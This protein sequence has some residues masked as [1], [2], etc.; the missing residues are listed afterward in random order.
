MTDEQ[1]GMLAPRGRAS[2]SDGED[3]GAVLHG[4]WG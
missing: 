4:L 3:P 2:P 1:L